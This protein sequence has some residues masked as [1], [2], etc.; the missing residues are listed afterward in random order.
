MEQTSFIC[1]LMLGKQNVIQ[2]RDHI[3]VASKVFKLFM[4][5]TGWE[6]EEEKQEMKTNMLARG[7]SQH[8]RHH[9]GIC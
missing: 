7:W 8:Y 9:Q 1:C 4:Q 6:K 2:K 3:M 5:C